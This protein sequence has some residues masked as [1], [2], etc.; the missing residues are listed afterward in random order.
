MKW[1]EV[2]EH[3]WVR[4]WDACE[5]HA[6]RVRTCVWSGVKGSEHVY[7]R[8][9]MSACAVRYAWKERAFMRVRARE[10]W[11]EGQ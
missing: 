10:V 8:M 9:S 11:S 5:R 1:S 6:T 7:S 4:V 2:R 3:V